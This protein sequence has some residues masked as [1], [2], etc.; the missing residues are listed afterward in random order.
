M[1]GEAVM[2]PHPKWI[3]TQSECGLALR[4]RIITHVLVLSKSRLA[5]IH[6]TTVVEWFTQLH[7]L[8]LRHI[9]PAG[10]Q[11]A[12]G[13]E[14]LVDQSHRAPKELL[15]LDLLLGEPQQ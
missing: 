15:M 7:Y 2:P 11:A 1:M 4:P 9:F 13:A 5:V 14:T 3:P 6:L 8:D 10:D 12:V